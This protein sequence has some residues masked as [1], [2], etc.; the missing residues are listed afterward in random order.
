LL[1]AAAISTAAAIAAARVTGRLRPV[2]DN[3]FKSSPNSTHACLILPRIGGEHA[4]WRFIGSRTNPGKLEDESQFSVAPVGWSGRGCSRLESLAP[5]VREL[6]RRL[7][8][9][10]ADRRT[11]AARLPLEVGYTVLPPW[12]AP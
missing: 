5:R 11:V 9:Y 7:V 6:P 3:V 8:R 12:L 4:R 10:L 1:H 2:A